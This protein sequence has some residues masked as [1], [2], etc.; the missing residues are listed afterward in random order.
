MDFT[1]LIAAIAVF[2]LLLVISFYILVY[3]SH[4]EERWTTWLPRITIVL[5][6][7]FSFLLPL[8][9]PFD[10]INTQ[11]EGDIPMDLVWQVI[12]LIDLVL[13]GFFIP[14]SYFHYESKVDEAGFFKA[15]FMAL[16]KSIFA[17]IVFIVFGLAL[18]FK[19]GYADIPVQL[20]TAPLTAYASTPVAST[21][22]FTT[23]T[24]SIRATLFVYFIGFISLIGS[25]FFA[26]F[27]GIGLAAVPMDLINAFRTRPRCLKASDWAKEKQFFANRSKCLLDVHLALEEEAKA[28]RTEQELRS[29][30]AE[31]DPARKDKML[32]NTRA[33]RRTLQSLRQS[34]S[35]LEKEYN[36]VLLMNSK[37]HANPLGYFFKLVMGILALL[38]SLLWLAQVCLTSLLDEPIYPL[39]DSLFTALA[40][41]SNFELLVVLLY[42][43][44]S[45]YLMMAVV[46]GV[47]K[48][49]FRF[50]LF[51]A[52]HP[53]ERDGTP[54][55]SFLF[56][57]GL[58]LLTAPACLQFCTKCFSQFSQDTA[59]DLLFGQTIDTLRGFSMW[60]TIAPFVFVGVAVLSLLLLLL[61]PSKPDLSYAEKIAKDE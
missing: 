15:L 46:K 20:F 56:N 29:I 7:T 25:F 42:G 47:T 58:L 52:I 48:F 1:L 22:D 40:A 4:P 10:V 13:L 5:S 3:W 30:D 11:T 37:E 18:W 36:A 23:A 26:F 14:F 49:G 35:T 43:A 61:C 60:F 17:A 16:I 12:S 27:G 57:A 8:L 41:R 38:L 45:L 34:L 31:T 2:V 54:M 50:V 51:I 53:M 24:S 28:S 19:F 6:I 32:Y 55:N 39:M 59:A 9:V 21:V 44:F 33:H